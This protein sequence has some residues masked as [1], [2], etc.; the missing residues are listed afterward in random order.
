M[1]FVHIGIGR[2]ASTFLQNKIFPYLNDIQYLGK[3]DKD[4]PRW[5]IDWQYADEFS[6]DPENIKASIQSIPKT[7]SKQLISSESFSMYGGYFK[8]VVERIPAVLEC[9]KIIY[10]LRDPIQ[11]IISRYNHGYFHENFNAPINDCLDFNRS[12][13]MFY[14]RKPIYLPDL[15]YTEQIEWLN[16]RFGEENILILK[17]ENM[18]KKP[19]H[20][21]SDLAN[22]MEI[23]ISTDIWQPCIQKK[24]NHSNLKIDDKFGLLSEDNLA[25]LKVYFADRTYG[26][27]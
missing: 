9:P 5:L 27:Y 17:Y 19:L 15:F 10:V 12:P 25:K 6:F 7:N 20:F 24:E 18:V 13:L 3:T 4:Y 16:K 14:K 23:D 26:Y 8:T 2:T 1:N 22:F 21:F 11:H